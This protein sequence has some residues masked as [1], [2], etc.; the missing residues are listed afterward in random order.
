MLKEHLTQNFI[1]MKVKE[2]LYQQRNAEED[3]MGSV[4]N[5]VLE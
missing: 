2:L 4:T 5:S 3:L 1:P